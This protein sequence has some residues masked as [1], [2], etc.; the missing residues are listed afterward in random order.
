[1]SC[2]ADFMTGQAARAVLGQPTFTAQL[3]GASD[4]AFGGIGGLAYANNTLFATDANRL[5]LLPNNNRVLIF[6]NIGQMLPPADAELQPYT[7]RCPMCG[8]RA[9]AALGQP[10]FVSTASTISASGMRLPTGV[11][12]DGRMLAVADTQN[13]RVLLWK[14]IPSAN[15]QPAD[16]VLGQT[17][18][19]RG[20]AQYQRQY[21]PRPTGCLDPKRQTF[22]GRHAK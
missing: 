9:S 10:D 8:G 19:N 11:A 21:V 5:G 15:G 13:N 22:R 17:N 7:G 2:G 6:N 1:M 14:T 18:F 12:S 20:S 16:V 4:T 3:S